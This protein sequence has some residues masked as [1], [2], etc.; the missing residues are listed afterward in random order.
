MTLEFLH[1]LEVYL[2]QKRALTQEFL[3]FVMVSAYFRILGS[4]STRT[5]IRRVYIF[6]RSSSMGTSIHEVLYNET[7]M[8]ARNIHF[9]IM[10]MFIN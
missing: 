5:S 6:C 10:I 2:L 1:G 3:T 9:L 8:T 4:I 7:E